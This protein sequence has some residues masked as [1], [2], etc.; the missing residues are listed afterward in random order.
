MA[1]RAPH[2]DGRRAGRRHPG[3]HVGDRLGDRPRRARASA[4]TPTTCSRDVLGLD[5]DEIEQL[6]EDGSGMSAAHVP[7]ALPGVARRA[8][9]SSSSRASTPRSAGKLLADL[10]ADVDRR[11]AA[12]RPSEPR[13]TGRSLDDEP[14]PERSLWWWY[15]NTSKRSVVLDLADPDGAARFRDLVA[16]RRHRARRRAQRPPGGAR[17]R[18]RLLRADHPELVWVVGHA[19]RPL[20]SRAPRRARP[21]TSRCSPAAVRRGTAATTTTRSRP[22]AGA[23]TRRSTSR[24]CSRR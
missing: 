8:S 13:A 2:R 17:P 21:P 24:A 14:G 10:G 3:A 15:Y 18:P 1:R 12:R 23:A 11:R 16:R 20:G 7:T 4:S 5:D 6:H 22:C 9:R 19:L